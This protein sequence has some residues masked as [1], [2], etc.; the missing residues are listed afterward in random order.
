[1]G[2]RDYLH[3]WLRCQHRRNKDRHLLRRYAISH[4]TYD[5][6]GRQTDVTDAAGTHTLTFNVSG[7]LQ[8]EQI[9]GGI[10]DGAGITIGY[11]SFLRRNSLQTTRGAN[12]LSSQTYGYDPSS[13]L[14][15]VT[16]G[17]QTATYGYDANSGLL[18]TTSFTSGTTIALTYEG[19][20]RLHTITT[21]PTADTPQAYTYTSNNLNQRT[22]VTREDGSYWSY[23]YNDRGELFTGRKYWADNSIVW[24]AQTEYN[25]DNIGN[26]K[27]AKN[28]GTSLAPFANQITTPIRSTNIRS[29]PFRVPWT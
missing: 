28:G 9:A 15:T 6:G 14:L 22:R 10:L 1:L 17:T 16:S 3:V 2:T 27:S 11:D 12:T 7:E 26:S 4:L 23:V 25:F 5:R 18:N 19:P 21:T 8:T 20:G 24:G 29:E 13:R